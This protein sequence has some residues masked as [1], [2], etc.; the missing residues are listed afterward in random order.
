M[1]INN[2]ILFK[3]I[4]ISKIILFNYVWAGEYWN[5]FTGK[6]PD[7]KNENYYS[8]KCDPDRIFWRK[9]PSYGY[10]FD[11]ITG[12]F[13]NP[14]NN[15]REHKFNKEQL[16]EKAICMRKSQE[17]DNNLSKAY[18]KKIE[19]LRKTVKI[20]NVANILNYLEYDDV[21]GQSSEFWYL[22]DKSKCIYRKT[23][24]AYFANEIINQEIKLEDFDSRYLEI[25]RLSGD[26]YYL[27]YHN[28]RK[29]RLNPS[30][31]ISKA[32]NGLKT[33][34]SKYCKSTREPF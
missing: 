23:F 13:S 11:V 6:Y 19:D 21:N 8:D 33:I 22:Y 14:P 27:T 28:E 15:W 18:T 12:N 17:N 31:D 10:I 20:D 16:D 25:Q 4:L 32:R 30:I 9:E 24:K 34:Y 5:E 2:K 7:L 29:L 1:M 26:D 3:F